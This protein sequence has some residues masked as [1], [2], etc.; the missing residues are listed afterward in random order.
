MWIQKSSCVVGMRNSSLLPPTSYLF[1]E[2][3]G[4]REEEGGGRREKEGGGGRR[5]EEGAERREKEGGGRRREEGTHA[6]NKVHMH[7]SRDKRIV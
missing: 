5:S 3:G 7:R 6:S 2:E 1:C 4:R